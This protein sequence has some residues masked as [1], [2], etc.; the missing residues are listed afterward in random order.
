MVQYN[1]NKNKSCVFQ[2]QLMEK[3]EET[4]EFFKISRKLILCQSLENTTHIYKY[5]QT[6]NYYYT[7]IYILIY[8]HPQN[9]NFCDHVILRASFDLTAVHVNQRFRFFFSFFDVNRKKVRRFF[10]SSS[11]LS[12]KIKL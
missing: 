11:S 8:N 7:P 12:S 4:S 10:V 9:K 6:D 5:I 1:L 2:Q 3:I